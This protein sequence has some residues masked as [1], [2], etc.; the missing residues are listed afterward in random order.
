LQGCPESITSSFKSANHSLALEFGVNDVAFIELQKTQEA[1]IDAM[2]WDHEKAREVI[3]RSTNDL[4]HIGQAIL[5]YVCRFHRIAKAL[6]DAMMWDHEK[7]QEVIQRSTNDL[8]HIGRAILGYV[9]KCFFFLQL[10]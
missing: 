10:T 3:Q 2:M 6:I 1:L 9:C 8:S 5:G 4:L 7:A